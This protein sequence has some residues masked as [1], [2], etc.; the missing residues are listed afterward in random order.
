MRLVAAVAAGVDLWI[1]HGKRNGSA[2]RNVGDTEQSKSLS[3]YVAT[4]LE[5]RFAFFSDISRFQLTAMAAPDPLQSA[6]T[7]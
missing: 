3:N 7:C 6:Q 4:N 2:V 5:L 1:S